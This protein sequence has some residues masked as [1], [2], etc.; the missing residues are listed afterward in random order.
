MACGPFGPAARLPEHQRIKPERQAQMEASAQKLGPKPARLRALLAFVF[1]TVPA[2]AA[3]RIAG[4]AW[5]ADRSPIALVS[6]RLREHLANR[7][8]ATTGHWHHAPPPKP[9]EDLA[10]SDAYLM[11]LEPAKPEGGDE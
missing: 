4:G 9:P 1:A 3:E 11:L 8:K 10:S 6:Y 7:G 5:E 2:A